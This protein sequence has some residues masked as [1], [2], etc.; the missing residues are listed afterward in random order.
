MPP[1]KTP[2][3]N[4]IVEAKYPGI[5]EATRRHRAAWEQH[6]DLD[7]YSDE[8]LATL[9]EDLDSDVLKILNQGAEA[10]PDRE[11]PHSIQLERLRQF[12]MAA[13]EYRETIR[14]L[15]GPELFS[16]YGTEKARIEKL[17]SAQRDENDRLGFFNAPDAVADLAWWIRLPYWTRDEATALSLRRNPKMVNFETLRQWQF[18]DNS[19]FFRLFCERSELIERAD[20]AG[21]LTEPITPQAFITW[22]IERHH[23]WAGE[24][25]P[26]AQ[27]S[28]QVSSDEWEKRYNEVL[29]ERDALRQK[30]DR[31]LTNID[32]VNPKSQMSLFTLV[33]GMAVA[34]FG[35]ATRG[36]SSGAKIIQG[37]L[38]ELGLRMSQE[39]IKNWIQ[40]AAEEIDFV[41]EEPI[42][43]EIKG[44]IPQKSEI[45]KGNPK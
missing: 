33:A 9:M 10:Y 20:F 22:S 6:G 41:W 26:Y 24:F 32:E 36:N 14:L 3:I 34:R 12:L 13:E 45:G 17:Q 23:P 28:S 15:D 40:Q 4:L 1:I 2:Y 44:K 5:V 30:L 18:V 43:R 7:W 27:A 31:L 38:E 42:R 19:N 39:T 8:V 21:E 16:L 25:L 37:E 29:A 35:Y 11:I